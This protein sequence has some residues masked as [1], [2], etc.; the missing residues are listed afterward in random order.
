MRRH[1]DKQ[2]LTFFFL[3]P[4]SILCSALGPWSLTLTNHTPGSFGGWLP[5]WVWPMPE[6]E[7]SKRERQ[8]YFFFL[9]STLQCSI[10][11]R[12][13]QPP[14]LRLCQAVFLPG[15][16]LSPGY[17]TLFPPFSTLALS[18]S[19]SP[20]LPNSG[21]VTISGLVPLMLSIPLKIVLSWKFLHGN[22]W[23]NCFLPGPSMYQNTERQNDVQFWGIQC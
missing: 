23:L 12:Y 22:T 8:E 13:Q 6:K 20:L 14:W 21:W 5:F 4:Q 18:G 19:S 11:G 10:S 3:F 7:D 17:I 1:I 15:H 9:P 2:L 16:H